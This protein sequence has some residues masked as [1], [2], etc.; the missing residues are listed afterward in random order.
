MLG[1]LK[2]T[3][4]APERYT[5]N[6][7]VVLYEG[8]ENTVG[9]TFFFPDNINRNSESNFSEVY[10]M[11]T[12]I[13]KNGMTDPQ[14]VAPG[15]DETRVSYYF[16]AKRAGRATVTFYFVPFG[17]EYENASVFVGVFEVDK[18]LNVTLKS[19]KEVIR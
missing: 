16:T 5:F 3:D 11:G 15:S 17:S 7:E 12:S 19:M 1:L 13:E 9:V 4:L 2:A 18:D 8:C 14:K 10:I 6:S